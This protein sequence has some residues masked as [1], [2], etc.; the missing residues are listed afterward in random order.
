MV[1]LNLE[2][3][4]KKT[5]AV[6]PIRHEE[7]IM[8]LLKRCFIETTESFEKRQ[9]FWSKQNWRQEWRKA[10]GLDEDAESDWL[11]SQVSLAFQFDTGGR[12]I[13]GIPISPFSNVEPNEEL[14][15]PKGGIVILPRTKV[16]DYLT[17]SI[18]A[19]STSMI[20][21]RIEE[22]QKFA[23]LSTKIGQVV[24]DPATAPLA[25]G[26][27]GLVGDIIN[28]A[29]ALNK[30]SAL[31]DDQKRFIIDRQR[32][33][34]VELDELFPGKLEAHGSDINN[35]PNKT[36]L[37]LEVIKAPSPTKNQDN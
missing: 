3:E 2:F 30:P 26:A 12:M 19:A 11:Q 24:L 29:I 33:P 27:V 15:I 18:K 14:Y 6:D 32:Y 23:Q 20:M 36:T 1:F 4:N 31:V 37:E 22:V 21:S 17:V 9:N 7:E 35:K 10:F 28:L 16:E 5:A 8:V 25:Y 34:T 13:N